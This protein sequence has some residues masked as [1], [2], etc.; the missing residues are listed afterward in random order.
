LN[1]LTG[2][3]SLVKES[4]RDSNVVMSDLQY[5]VKKARSFGVH[6][7]SI[8]LSNLDL[9][10]SPAQ[11]DEFADIVGTIKSDNGN[12]PI[13]MRGLSTV[14]SF[15]FTHRHYPK[16][17]DKLKSVG[18][19]RIGFGI[20]GSA[21]K[22]WKA[23]R[24]PNTKNDCLQAIVLT[25]KEYGLTP[26]TLMVF[27]HNQYDNK[28]S[29]RQAY[30]FSKDMQEI[31]GAIPRPHVAKDVIPGNDGWSNPVNKNIINLLLAE[32][33][34]FQSL[35]FTAAPSKLTHPDD[36]FRAY[37]TDYFI[38]VCGLRSGS[39]P[40]L[41]QYVL[42]IEPGMSESEVEKVKIFNEGKYDI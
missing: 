17:I 5:L 29:L 30:E 2:R 41:T 8:Y 11:L 33:Q 39:F 36:E 9:F 27:G 4:Y 35:D 34:L 15:I 3:H 1:N 14:S 21:P 23:T 6:Q 24:K 42:P 18:L 10:Q 28:E 7:L 40:A 31:Y 37:A 20:D 26:E 12:F 13:Y 32:P 19:L 22:V 38:K 16:I 25:R